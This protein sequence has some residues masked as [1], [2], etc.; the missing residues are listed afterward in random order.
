MSE[1]PRIITEDEI[2]LRA[3]AQVLWRGRRLILY[4]TGAIIALSV[5]YA[6]LLTPLF[7]ATITL[8]PSTPTGSSG[9]GQLEGIAASF[10]FNI[11]GSETTFHIPDI[12]KSRRL[13]TNIL[14][15]KWHSTEFTDP[16]D[17]I[18]YWEIN[19]T[20]GFSLDPREWIRTLLIPGGKKRDPTAKWEDRGLRKLAERISVKETR[21]DL[22][23]V[24]VWMEEP[25]MA[26]DVANYI[27][28]AILEYTVNVHNLQARLNREFIE[29]RRNEVK[30]ELARAEEAL[31]EF[32][33]RNRQVSESPELQMELERLR[34]EVLIQTEVY[35]TLRQQYELARIEEVKETP[36]VVFLDEARPPV[37]KDRP[38]RKRLVIMTMLFGLFV[39]SVT[40]VIRN[41]FNQRSNWKQNVPSIR[42]ATNQPGQ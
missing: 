2:N 9:L 38:R 24:A 21:S 18:T 14:H 37:E 34:R 30:N 29:K 23:R 16:V 35:I 7:K 36:S 20:T 19:D 5:V 12:V 22:I 40:V 15:N 41:I 10:G 42:T 39:S 33:D 11:G 4:I 13:H 27:Y 3:V 31:K 32:R 8:Y 1:E 6:L 25:R 17:M 28:N 26:A